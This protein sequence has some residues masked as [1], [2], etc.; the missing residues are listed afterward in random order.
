[1]RAAIASPSAAV[2]A[3]RS[4]NRNPKRHTFFLQLYQDT[5]HP[6]ASSTFANLTAVRGASGLNGYSSERQTK[7]PKV[8]FVAFWLGFLRA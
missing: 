1:M 8:N 5:A 4:I 3:F 2:C 6:I 7:F